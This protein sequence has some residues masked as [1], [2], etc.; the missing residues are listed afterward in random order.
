MTILQRNTDSNE[1]LNN[2]LT[3]LKKDVQ[4]KFNDM[5]QKIDDMQTLKKT[6]MD[7]KEKEPDEDITSLVLELK[8][9][10]KSYRN[11]EKD[12]SSIKEKLYKVYGR[13][14]FGR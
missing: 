4:R 2:D 3:N 7:L 9:S 14:F 8:S 1:Q 5:Q 11:I 6:V 12:N 13:N 10:L